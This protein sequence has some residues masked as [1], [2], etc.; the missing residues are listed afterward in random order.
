MN[1]A[2]YLLPKEEVKYLNP[3]STI[4]QALEKLSYHK[5]TSVPLVSE[6]GQYVGTLTEG[7]L[8]WKLKEAFDLGFYDV[9]KTKLKDVPQRVNNISV[10]INSNME[11]LITLATDQNF[12]PVTDDDGH[13]IGIIRRRDIIKYCANTI[14]NNK[15]NEN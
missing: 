1:I 8:L 6:E 9:V 3:E 4:R 15:I 13:F 11:D 5:Y 14:W 10:S 2:F 7:D 12:I